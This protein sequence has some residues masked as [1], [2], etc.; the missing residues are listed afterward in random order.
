MRILTIEQA[1]KRITFVSDEVIREDFI[2]LT[3]KVI[4]LTPSITGT[5]RANWTIGLGRR[6][7]A[8]PKLKRR[9]PSGQATLA[10]ISQKV[11]KAKVKKKTFLTNSV[12]WIRKLEFHVP[13][14]MIQLTAAQHRPIANAAARRVLQRS[15]GLR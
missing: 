13:H 15:R 2:G 6:S 5:T 9:D 1:K 14:A 3:K 10:A 12:P 7:R 8:K 11:R 4:Q